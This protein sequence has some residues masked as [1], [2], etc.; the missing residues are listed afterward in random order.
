MRVIEEFDS[1]NSL[2]EYGDYKFIYVSAVRGLNDYF[3]KIKEYSMTQYGDVPQVEVEMADEFLE[4][5]IEALDKASKP[6]EIDTGL[7][8]SEFKKN[9]MST[10]R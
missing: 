2:K 5:I 8:L 1:K 10:I 6:M 7:F 3:T 4:I 9:V